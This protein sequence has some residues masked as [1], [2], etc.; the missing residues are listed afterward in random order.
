MR[1]CLD[2]SY[3]C[4]PGGKLG[5]LKGQIKSTLISADATA[6]STLRP[7]GRIGGRDMPPCPFGLG[8]TDLLWFGRI[9]AGHN[10]PDFRCRHVFWDSNSWT[11]LADV[12]PRDFHWSQH[13]NWRLGWCRM[14]QAPV[15]IQCCGCCPV[16][17]GWCLTLCHTQHNQSPAWSEQWPGT[18]STVCLGPLPTSS[19]QPLEGD[20]GPPC[21][22]S[23][24]HWCV[25]WKRGVSPTTA[26]GTLLSP[27]PAGMCHQ[28]WLQG[29]L[30]PWIGVQWNVW[31]YT[32]GLQ[33]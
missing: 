17:A 16:V 20:S 12:P 21:T 19:A 33:T 1:L 24:T 25:S 7:T 29:V 30:E 31:L 28:S 9:R 4:V 10:V 8:H 6:A 14:L 3:L 22:L 18:A 32:Y 23:L 2:G 26:Q 13:T 11:A 15:L 5:C 27:Q